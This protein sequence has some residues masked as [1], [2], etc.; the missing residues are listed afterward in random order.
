M[1]NSLQ[2]LRFIAIFIIFIS[3]YCGAINFLMGAGIGVYSVAFFTVLSGFVITLNYNDRFCDYSLKD[4]ARFTISR[5]KKFYWLHILTLIA[6]IYFIAVGIL[7][8]HEKLWD[9]IVKL[10]FNATLT[11]SYVPIKDVYFSYNAVSWYLSITLIFYFLSPF[12]VK[13]MERVTT[14]YGTV[15]WVILIMCFEFMYSTLLAT[16]SLRHW[17]IYI[18]PF[19]R[20]FDFILGCII[21]KQYMLSR[22][23]KTIW[24]NTIMEL[25][26]FA[27]SI[28]TIYFMQYVHLH[29]EILYF[30]LLPLYTVAA[31][32]LLFIIPY[33]KGR[34]TQWLAHNK[35]LIYL[36]GISFEFFM[37]HQLVIRYYFEKAG[38]ITHINTIGFIFCLSTTMLFSIIL[39]KT[40][41]AVTQRIKSRKHN[42]PCKE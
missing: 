19:F 42:P 33:E 5:V 35:Y 6:A 34:I 31:C 41:K 9:A 25:L 23:D 16:T 28:G 38:K 29:N 11:Q 13:T 15:R 10:F 2:S 32:I 36:G 24:E 26:V 8:S 39:Q 12:I 3:H 17:L 1:I 22:D 4:A 37:I 30:R 14:R 20:I 21:A 18:N 27:V 7:R 40:H